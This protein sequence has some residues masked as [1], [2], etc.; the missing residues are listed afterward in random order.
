[1]RAIK[2][3]DTEK[4]LPIAT[5]RALFDRVIARM[6]DGLAKHA[7]AVM[8][9]SLFLLEVERGEKKADK[10]AIARLT[11]Q[12]DEEFLTLPALPPH[13]NNIDLTAMEEIYLTD[14]ARDCEREPTPANARKADRT[15]RLVTRVLNAD[16]ASVDDL[17]HAAR[18][19]L[20]AHTQYTV[21]LAARLGQLPAVKTAQE[22]LQKEGADPEDALTALDNAAIAQLAS[23]DGLTPCTKA[24]LRASLFALYPQ[25]L[26][27]GENKDLIARAARR[28]QQYARQLS[29]NPTTLVEYRTLSLWCENNANA[30]AARGIEGD[31]FTAMLSDYHRTSVRLREQFYGKAAQGQ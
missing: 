15:C 21:C 30:L 8:R 5:V 27:Q 23:L 31:L 18:L 16:W 29:A 7:L 2:E 11:A 22:A 13:P 28:E 12:L 4:V 9:K 17:D 20:L 26:Q 19:S 6:P 3:A 1:M 14:L 10:A 25:I 24:L